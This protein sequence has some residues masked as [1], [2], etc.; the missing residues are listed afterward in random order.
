MTDLTLPMDRVM[1][2]YYDIRKFHKERSLL[3]SERHQSNTGGMLNFLNTVRDSK[4]RGHL[5]DVN[6]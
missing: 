1:L 6:T 5:V 2:K 4:C 3:E